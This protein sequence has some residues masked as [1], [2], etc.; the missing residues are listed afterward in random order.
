MLVVMVAIVEALGSS[1]DSRTTR[2]WLDVVGADDNIMTVML[3][4]RVRMQTTMMGI[5]YNESRRQLGL[6]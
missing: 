5:Q 6:L 2:A 1:N 3:F 4:L